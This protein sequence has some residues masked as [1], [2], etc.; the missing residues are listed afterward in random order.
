VRVIVTSSLSS[1][2]QSAVSQRTV[3]WRSRKGFDGAAGGAPSPIIDGRP[4]SLPIPF[5]GWGTADCRFDDLGLGAV[6]EHQTAGKVERTD[7]CHADPM[8][9]GGRCA[10]G[11]IG[12]ARGHLAK[13][14]AGVGDVFLFFGLFA[15]ETTRRRHHRL[16][17]Y[18]AVAEVRELGATPTS[19]DQPAG[20][21]RRHPHTTGRWP[22]GN[23]LDVGEGHAAT[24]AADALR[25]SVA[26]GPPS[27]W[28]VPAWLR[29]HRLSYHRPRAW[30]TPGTLLAARRGQD[31]GVDIGGDGEKTGWVERVTALIRTGGGGATGG[32]DGAT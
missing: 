29:R 27:L 26:A 8:F 23:T 31:F 11:P 7:P 17:G 12:A 14:G 3:D 28:R 6:V 20:F 30:T 9:E 10:L 19:A 13:Q 21:T 5:A 4:V 25:L 32:P 22:S 1:N 16:F 18:L 24:D 2:K 15:D